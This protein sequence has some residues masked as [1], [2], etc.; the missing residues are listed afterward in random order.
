MTQPK[1]LTLPGGTIQK[2]LL[3]LSGKQVN[4]GAGATAIASTVAGFE[5]AATS[6][7]APKCST[8][9]TDDCVSSS[10]ERSADI[11]YVGVTSDAPTVAANGQNP[12]TAGSL[13]FAVTTQAPWTTAADR[14]EFDIYLDLDRDGTADALIINT[15]LPGTD[16]LVAETIDLTTGDDLD[17]EPLDGRFGDTDVALFDSDTMVLPVAIGA[18]GI[19]KS[20]R[21]NYA[22]A[23]TSLYGEVDSIGFDS[24]G[25]PSG[26]RRT[27][28][29][30]STVSPSSK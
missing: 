13:Y 22:I 10:G 21:V 30:P 14:Q 17:I 12:A 8:K 26:S 18:L 6:G 7:L 19:T 4:Q 20:T 2:A 25:E 5:L 29:S 16:I 23:A 27:P 11:K 3:P 9:I 28:S 24:T 15:R 1:S